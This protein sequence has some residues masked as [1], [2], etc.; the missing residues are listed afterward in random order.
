MK[1]NVLLLGKSN[2]LLRRRLKQTL[3]RLLLHLFAV[4][5]V[6]L[7]MTA[8]KTLRQKLTFKKQK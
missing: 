7:R 4:S 5:A 6:I 8:Q 3:C 2:Q 1:E